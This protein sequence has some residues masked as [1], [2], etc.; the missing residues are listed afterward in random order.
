FQFYTVVLAS[1]PTGEVRRRRCSSVKTPA[2]SAAPQGSL[3]CA[4]EDHG[5][6]AVFAHFNGNNPKIFLA[7]C[8][9]IGRVALSGSLVVELRLVQEPL[10]PIPKNGEC[11][12]AS[13]SLH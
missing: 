4:A 7:G 11:H 6:V 1:R 9:R 5:A 12:V 8:K 3:P 10:L 13:H 2:L